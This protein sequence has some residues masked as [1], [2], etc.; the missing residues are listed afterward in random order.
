MVFVPAAAAAAGA[1]GSF[2]VTD[3]EVHNPGSKTVSYRF[4][5]LPREHDNSQPQQSDVFTL[6]P[7]GST[8]Y[9]D[10]LSEVFGAEDAVGA[11]ALLVEG[12]RIEV[13]SR[14]CNLSDDGSFGQSLPGFPTD[15]LMGSGERARI[16]FMTENDDFRSNLGLLNGSD[17]PITV[18]WRLFS[19]DGTQLGGGSVGLD[20]FGNTQINRVFGNHRPVDVG[21]VDVWTPTEG[22]SMTCYGSVVDNRSNDPM[23][24]LPR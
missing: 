6:A 11:V 12:G 10:I 4:L 24:V 21:Y 2:F 1:S 19:A 18:A 20:P 13:M 23:T 8:R 15:A 16:L 17:I 9:S 5:W 14:T 7:K 22:A 3:L